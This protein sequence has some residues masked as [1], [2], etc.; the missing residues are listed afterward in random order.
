MNTAPSML[1]VHSPLVGPST[2]EAT[3][4]RLRRLGR[5]VVVPSLARALE[6]GPP[7][8]RGIARAAARAAVDVDPRRPIVLVGHSGA[9]SLLPAI[10]EE[11]W[12]RAAAVFVDALLPHPGHS[13]FDSAPRRLREHLI[14]LAADGRLPAW[15]EWFPP[16]SLVALIPD[17]AARERFVAELPRIPLSYFEEPAVAARDLPPESCAYIQ[18]SAAYEGQAD[19]AARR[20]WAVRRHDADHLT[21]LT[22]PDFVAELLDDAVAALPDR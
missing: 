1:L 8:H 18:L 3:A 6:Q 20:G 17:A 21:M 9:G 13:W 5:Q 15:N 4:Q 10:A 14:G 19:E 16:E 11:T 2:W 22:R 12:G 7:F